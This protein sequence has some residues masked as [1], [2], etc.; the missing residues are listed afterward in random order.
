MPQAT[1]HINT[2]NLFSVYVS[3]SG[4]LFDHSGFVVVFSLAL[5]LYATCMVYTMLC[6]RETPSGQEYV[7][8]SPRMPKVRLLNIKS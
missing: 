6:M 4:Y 7:I 1:C 8:H 2:Y 3:G 5:T